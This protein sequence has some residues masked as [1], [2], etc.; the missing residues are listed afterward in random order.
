MCAHV[1]DYLEVLA[2]PAVSH[3]SCAV[4]ADEHGAT[5][6]EHMVVIERISIGT[7]AERGQKDECEDERL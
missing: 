6:L 2:K 5:R 4:A 3:H 7:S 1:T